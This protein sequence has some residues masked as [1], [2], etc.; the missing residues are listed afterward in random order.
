MSSIERKI[1]KMQYGQEKNVVVDEPCMLNYPVAAVFDETREQLKTLVTF[2]DC[3][4]DPTVQ[5]FADINKV[6]DIVNAAEDKCF[7]ETVGIKTYKQMMWERD[8]AIEQLNELGYKFGE[9]INGN[10]IRN[11]AIEEFAEAIK[12]LAARN[13]KYDDFVEDSEVDEIAEQLKAVQDNDG[14]ILCDDRMPKEYEKQDQGRTWKVSEEVQVTYVDSDGV[15]QV[16][17][18]KTYNSKWFYYGDM[19]VAWQPASKPYIG[20]LPKEVN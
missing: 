5:L 20:P 16:G 15:P 12:Q 10:R 14:W 18:D 6:F 8:I 7:R 11:K 4:G 17:T 9:K 2:P 1:K 3:I 19:V 13:F